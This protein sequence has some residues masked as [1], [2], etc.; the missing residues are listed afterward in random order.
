M[1]KNLLIIALLP[2]LFF[3]MAS[4]AMEKEFEQIEAPEPKE[5]P[6]GIGRIK[7]VNRSNWKLQVNY[8]QANKK[9]SR[10]IV[11]DGELL[12]GP[13]KDISEVSI[14]SYGQIWGAVVQVYPVDLKEIKE[15]S[16]EDVTVEIK[17][18]LTAWT[19]TP[20]WLGVHPKA[21]LPQTEDPWDAFLAVR[22]RR[23]A[24]QWVAPRHVLGLPENVSKDEV[25]KA[26]KD[27]SLKW[28]PDKHKGNEELATAI[29]QI[30]ADAKATLIAYHDTL[31]DIEKT[32]QKLNE[33]K[34]LFEQKENVLHKGK[35]GKSAIEEDIKK[36]ETNIAEAKKITSWYE[37]LKDS[38][39]TIVSGGKKFEKWNSPALEESFKQTQK[40]MEGSKEL[41]DNMISYL[42][43][44]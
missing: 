19:F 40:G 2:I 1:K 44:L 41:A 15:R 20:Q 8:I 43:N 11:G 26:F 17:A 36:I 22:S 42:K 9:L 14:Q 27:L 7:L 38:T 23:N 34:Q 29:Q 35:V 28:H 39:V 24:G 13:I 33:L 3:G 5:A 4:H 16:K 31:A 30:I 12:L 6:R 25:I 37:W 18:T 32:E 21:E 10:T